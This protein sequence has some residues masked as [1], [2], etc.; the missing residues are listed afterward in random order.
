MLQF[1][2]NIWGE[3]CSTTDVQLYLV[4]APGRICGVPNETRI[5]Y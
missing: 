4:V 5:H 1:L 2:K 3:L